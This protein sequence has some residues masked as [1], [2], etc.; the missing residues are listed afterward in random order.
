MLGFSP[1]SAAALG[2]DGGGSGP[3][4]IV[5]GNP[6]VADIQLTQLHVI[7]PANLVSGTPVVSSADLFQI[8]GIVSG[9]P[10]V[11]DT[12]VTQLHVFTTSGIVTG[13]PV[14]EEVTLNGS[15]RRAVNITA[16]SVNNVFIYEEYKKAV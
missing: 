6:V 16:S 8:E 9:T 5:T 13:T 12:T 11:N 1:L 10:V 7:S 2:D 3:A 15:F 14:V 4:S